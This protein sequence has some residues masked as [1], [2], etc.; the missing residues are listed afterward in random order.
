MERGLGE[1]QGEKS[2]AGEIIE[3]LL[4]A[5]FVFTLSAGGHDL[6][7]EYRGAGQPNMEMVNRLM[8][9]LS[10]LKPEA[11]DYLLRREINE[12][13]RYAD[14]RPELGVKYKDSYWWTILFR[15]ALAANEDLY[16][17]LRQFRMLGTVLVEVSRKDGSGRSRRALRPIV[18]THSWRFVAGWET[19]GEYAE[20]RK[21]YLDPHKEV[22]LK[23]LEE[24][25]EY[26]VR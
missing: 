12:Q 13:Q 5:G 3:Q 23:I 25:S 4:S 17:R 14:P 26:E 10:A 19:K 9:Q 7:F 8:S 21:L 16:V 15:L 22:L 20:Q 2:K 6:E 18:G 1:N 24:V 11:I